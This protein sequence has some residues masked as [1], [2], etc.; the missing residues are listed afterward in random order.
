MTHISTALFPG[1]INQ[2]LTF[3]DEAPSASDKVCLPA[4]NSPWIGKCDPTDV[5]MRPRQANPFSM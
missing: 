2:L 5:A 1:N 3:Q 4:S